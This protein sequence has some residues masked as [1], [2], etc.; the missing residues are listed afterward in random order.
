MC[1][2]MR[3]SVLLVPVCFLA[4][5]STPEPKSPY[6]RKSA[7][8]APPAHFQPATLAEFE[9]AAARFKAVI[10]LPRLEATPANIQ[11]SV[12]NTIGRAE[13]AL[14]AIAS[15]AHEELTFGNTIVALDDLSY[16]IG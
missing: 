6:A 9:K 4:A 1:V 5:C 2:T 14:D 13:A 8:S 10:R 12:S 7:E 16:D 15:C 3:S 11:R